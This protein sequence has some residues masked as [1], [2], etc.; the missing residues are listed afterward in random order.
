MLVCMLVCVFS[1]FELFFFFFF[2]SRRRHTRLQGDWSSDVCSSDLCSAGAEG[3]IDG[4][5]DGAHRKEIA[6]GADYLV[7]V[8]IGG[9]LFVGGVQHHP[10][11]HAELAGGGHL[12][13]DVHGGEGASGVLERGDA[14]GEGF[15]DGEADGF[16]GFGEAVGGGAVGFIVG[17]GAAD[18]ALGAFAEE[19]GGRAFGV[20]EDLSARRV[21]CLAGDAGEIEGLAVD[22]GGVSAGVGED[23]RVVGGDFVE[24]GVER[25]A[26]DIGA[27]RGGPFGLVPA[28]ADNPFAGLGLFG[29]AGH[30]S[31]DVVPGAGFAEVEA[32]AEFADAGEM[33]VAFDEAGN[34]Q[35]AVEVD[36]SGVGAGPLGGDAIGA[37]C[38]N[39]AGAYGDGLRGGRGGVHGDDVIDAG[40]FLANVFDHGARGTGRRQIAADD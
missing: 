24:G 25:E 14:F 33:S 27:G 1:L 21:R 3:A 18:D 7:A 32:H 20:L 6:A 36:D 38:G 26:F 11:A 2:S 16:V 29:G 39:L 19:A 22:E 17:V 37:E 4:A 30:L 28:A 34:G 31:D 9:E 5:F 15:V 35:H 40:D 10:D 13:E 23:Y 12:L 8:Q